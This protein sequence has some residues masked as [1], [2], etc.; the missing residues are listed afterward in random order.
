MSCGPRH[1]C[2]E[3]Q[4]TRDERTEQVE[5]R[6]ERNHGRSLR[7]VA[8]HEMGCR[9]AADR[10]DRRDGRQ[11]RRDPGQG[12]DVGRPDEAPLGRVTRAPAGRVAPE[13]R[14]D[15]VAG[16]HPVGR[17]LAAADADDAGRLD[18]D[19]VLP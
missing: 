1:F 13:D 3:E 8:R 4:P 16:H 12:V 17:V 2:F 9:P 15:D 10:C 14:I 7:P 19:T 5:L 6:A 18:R 11:F